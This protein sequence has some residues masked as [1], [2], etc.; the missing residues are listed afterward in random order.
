MQQ[1]RELPPHGCKTPR[2]VA[3]AA[4]LSTTV[5]HT[6]DISAGADSVNTLWH[7]LRSVLP[8]I[9]TAPSIPAAI[10]SFPENAPNRQCHQPF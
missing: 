7:E 1:N 6:P 4:A 9:G 10:F 3:W 5:L 8:E 2:T